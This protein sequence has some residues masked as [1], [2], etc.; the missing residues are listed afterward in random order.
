MFSIFS[1]PFSN[2]AWTF[3]NNLHFN[4]TQDV[5]FTD[6]V[7]SKSGRLMAGESFSIAFRPG[8]IELELRPKY[9]IQ[10]STN[11]IQTNNNRVIHTYGGSFNGTWYTRFGL[12]LS[13]ELNYTA[14]SGY[15]QGYN[16]K[17]WMW[18]ATISY[19][20]LK[21]K[22]ATIALEGKDLLNQHQSV[23]RTISAQ[24]ITDTENYILGR[25]VMLTFTYKFSTFAGGK[26]PSVDNEFT[27]MGPPGGGG[28]GR[29]GPGGPH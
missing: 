5:G 4:Y 25:Y 13:T 19:M 21:A 26:T 17:E 2:K 14:N 1:R 6:G 18:N 16:T 24:A 22:N 12:V 11:D 15:S 10:Y 7:K 27:R 20:F 9:D 29:R 8:D 3:N 28:P 23:N